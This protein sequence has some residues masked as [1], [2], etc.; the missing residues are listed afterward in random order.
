MQA[1]PPAGPGKAGRS[2]LLVG[3]SPLQSPLPKGDVLRAWKS[4][5]LI[6]LKEDRAVGR[7]VSSWDSV[8]STAG[9]HAGERGKELLFPKWSQWYLDRICRDTCVSPWRGVKGANPLCGWWGWKEALTPFPLC[10]VHSCCEGR[11]RKSSQI[12]PLF[13]QWKA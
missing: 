12:F 5:I 6:A 2:S 11:A 4:L 1:L 8:T 10:W 7:A 3:P 9:T 13:T